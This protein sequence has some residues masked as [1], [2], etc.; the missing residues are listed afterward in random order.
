[1][2]ESLTTS[3]SMLPRRLQ[4]MMCRREVQN[5][6]NGKGRHANTSVSWCTWKDGPIWMQMLVATAKPSITVHLCIMSA[7]A[8]YL[9]LQH[10]N[11]LQDLHLAGRL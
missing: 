6:A 8:I 4:I 9:G 5:G 1:M 11:A 7:L 10:L 3:I 2:S